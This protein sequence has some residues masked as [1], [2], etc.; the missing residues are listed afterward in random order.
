[1]I[2]AFIPPFGGII[3]GYLF[4]ICDLINVFCLDFV[5]CNLV[6]AKIIYLI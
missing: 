1:M 2:K 3:G 4:R 6:L 5:A